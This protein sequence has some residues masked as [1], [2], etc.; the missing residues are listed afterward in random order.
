MDFYLSEGND[1]LRFPLT[2]DSIQIKR[3]TTAI[4]FNVINKGE[5]KIPRGTAVTG[6]SWNG[7][8]PGKS[9]K[10][11]SFVFDWKQPKKLADKLSK[12]L[13]ENTI[14]KFMVSGSSINDKVFIESF[15][16]TLIGFDSYQYT[17]SL[18]AYRPLTITTQKKKKKPKPEPEETTQQDDPQK[19]QGEQK[20]PVTPENPDQP[21]LSVDIPGT[22]L[23]SSKN[24]SSANLTVGTGG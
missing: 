17:I 22:G 14:L 7:L 2:P 21:I 10:G 24:N 11:Q 3:G 5:H 19:P 4:S 8:L 12:W 9:M 20:P 15:V 16:C 23:A 18:S 6:Y 13:E 1:K